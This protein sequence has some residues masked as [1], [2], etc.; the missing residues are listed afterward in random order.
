MLVIKEMEVVLYMKRNV[1][2][3]MKK[4]IAFAFLEI[5][6][7]SFPPL[8]IA[9]FNFLIKLFLVIFISPNHKPLFVSI[10][11]LMLAFVFVIFIQLLFIFAVMLIFFVVPL[12]QVFTF[13]IVISSAF[14]IL[15]FFSYLHRTYCHRLSMQEHCLAVNYFCSASMLVWLNYCWI[16]WFTRYFSSMEVVMLLLVTQLSSMKADWKLQCYYLML[17]NFFSSMEV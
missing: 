13:L 11:N 9:S 1:F 17:I 3:R 14:L 15:T 4:G 12:F 8:L 6:Y 5:S 10:F 7:C 2:Q 16:V